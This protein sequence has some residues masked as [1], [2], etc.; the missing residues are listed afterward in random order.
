MQQDPRF[1]TQPQL[2]T[3]AEKL[4][5]GLGLAGSNARKEDLV[6]L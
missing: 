1:G 3:T 6:V 2:Q 5:F 4:H